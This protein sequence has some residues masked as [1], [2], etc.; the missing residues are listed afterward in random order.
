MTKQ[1]RKEED[2]EN[3]DVPDGNR[4]D[5]CSVNCYSL[6]RCADADSR[7]SSLCPADYRNG[8]DVS[9]GLFLLRRIWQNITLENMG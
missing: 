1:S 5:T 9:C 8:W 2:N 3:M 4:I 7:C 6:Q